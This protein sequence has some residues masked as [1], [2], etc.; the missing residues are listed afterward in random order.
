MKLES[1][2]IEAPRTDVA[3]VQS[4]IKKS[5]ERDRAVDVLRGWAIVLMTMSHVGRFSYLCTLAHLPL[6]IT[7]AAFFFGLSGVV[8]G[9]VS[10]RRIA[11]TAPRQAYQAIWKRART[12]WVIHCVLL[13][14]LL[15]IQSWHPLWEDVPSM[16]AVGGWGNALWMVPT[17]YLQSTAF[18][19]ILPLYVIFMLVTPLALEGLRRRQAPFVLLLS[20]ALYLASQRYPGMLRLAHP[21]SGNQVFSLASWQFLF[22]GGLVAGYYREEIVT[23]FWPQNRAWFFPLCVFLCTLFFLVAQSQRNL[24]TP[25]HLHSPIF[26]SRLFWKENLGPGLMLYFLL[27]VIVA[28]VVIHR[29]L[30]KKV[31]WAKIPL[32]W[33]MTLG[34]QSLYCFLVHLVFALISLTLNAHLWPH[35]AQ[36][37]YT[38]GC[39]ILL[40]N[41]AKHRVFSRY[42]PN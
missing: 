15:L 5:S 24:F 37:L 11:N 30:K 1:Q 18:M 42:I 31:A 38:A 39:L 20:F 6:Y 3:V 4:A 19:N 22:F 36:E 41:M 32:N 40:Y 25:L 27:M 28:Y 13:F 7:A 34:Q 14:S 23:R 17:L 16:R 2:D 29:L 9:M 8:L 33:L 35:L 12:L 21:A 26:G 10:R